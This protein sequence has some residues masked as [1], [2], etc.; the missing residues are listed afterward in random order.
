MRRVS[1]KRSLVLRIY[2]KKRREY[3]AEHDTCEF[4]L[5]CTERAT[6]IQHLRGR[7]GDRLLREEWW[8]ASCW[9]HNSW[10]EDH[11]GEALAIGWLHKIE[12]AGVDGVERA[13]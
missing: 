13:G 12:A 2:A 5:G 3:L 11:T 1:R 7:F 8:A 10:A 4:P 6:T 9:A